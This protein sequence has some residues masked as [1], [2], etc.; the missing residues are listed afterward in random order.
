MQVPTL[1]LL[2]QALVHSWVAYGGLWLLYHA[3]VMGRCL[4][5]PKHKHDVAMA[6]QS[7]GFFYFVYRLWMVPPPALLPAGSFISTDWDPSPY[8]TWMGWLYLIAFVFALMRLIVL[9]MREPLKP[10]A[11]QDLPVVWRHWMKQMSEQLGLRQVPRVWIS[12]NIST[13]RI[14]GWLKSAIVLPVAC[15]NQLSPQQ[16]E[17]LLLHELE[18][19][20]RNDLW[21]NRWLMF[22]ET[23][24]YLNP[25]VHLF[26]SIIRKER[27]QA[28]DDMVLQ[29]KYNPYDYAQSLYRMAAGFS[30]DST[31]QLAAGGNSRYQLLQRIERMIQPNAVPRN[32]SLHWLWL[33]L[34]LALCFLQVETRVNPNDKADGSYTRASMPLNKSFF[35]VAFQSD[36]QKI[37][38]LDQPKQVVYS[39]NPSIY[40][41]AA[42]YREDLMANSETLSY[43]EQPLLVQQ[44]G[45][46][47]ALPEYALPLQQLPQANA[48]L[49]ESGR[50]FIQNSSLLY[51][52]V[53]GDD[54][55]QVWLEKQRWALGL[56]RMAELED[57][58]AWMA[59]QYK[60]GIDSS[61]YIAVLQAE[62]YL[63]EKWQALQAIDLPIDWYQTKGYATLSARY[64]STLLYL[65]ALR[66]QYFQQETIQ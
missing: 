64:R 63:K 59:G 47:S 65:S 31:F 50:P 45:Q 35:T 49:S 27:E 34:P 48:L 19:I 21:W 24:L 66:L 1:P 46:V 6:L 22:M 60:P 7:L 41:V 15:L 55:T 14:Q 53:T 56:Q 17:A 51:H 25:F 26:G 30:T 42:P 3:L 10:A 13:P 52:A 40:P 18:H 39:T 44:V 61:G 12:E 57:L 16:C 54:S 23:C 37:K 9:S 62:R 5:T 32:P 4:S 43:E 28:C 2:G 58:M 20:R 33:C 38:S 11:D 36:I 29:W 8:W